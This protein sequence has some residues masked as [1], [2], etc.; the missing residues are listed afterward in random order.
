MLRQTLNLPGIVERLAAIEARL[1]AVETAVKRLDR[2]VEIL[3]DAVQKLSALPS[4]AARHTAYCS[5]FA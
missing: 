2:N 5:A 4:P 1:T 3:A